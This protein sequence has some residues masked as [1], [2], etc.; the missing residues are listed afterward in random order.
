MFTGVGLIGLFPSFVGAIG[1]VV[2]GAGL[3]L[4]I[5]PGSR[6]LD[7]IVCG[8]GVGVLPAGAMAASMADTGQAT[9]DTVLCAAYAL[10]SFTMIGA[11]LG[12][13][14][15]RDWRI[16]PLSAARPMLVAL[17]VLLLWGPLLGLLC[18]WIGRAWEATQRPPRQLPSA[19][20]RRD[21]S[22]PEPQLEGIKAPVRGHYEEIFLTMTKN[23]PVPGQPGPA[24]DSGGPSLRQV[25]AT[26]AALQFSYR[27]QRSASLNRDTTKAVG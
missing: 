5:A 18:L 13:M 20:A 23:H 4:I 27:N 17:P 11:V 24:G 25:G 12:M 22:T 6:M 16:W 26:A 19:V 10:T 1:C 21:S 3:G 7:G 14:S 2:L 8:L 15:R 9:A